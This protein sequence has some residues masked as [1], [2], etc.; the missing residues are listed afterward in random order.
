MTDDRDEAGP[1]LAQPSEA[2]ILAWAR[3]IS[4]ENLRAWSRAFTEDQLLEKATIVRDKLLKTSEVSDSLRRCRERDEAFGVP[5]MTL[6]PSP[7][8]SVSISSS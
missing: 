7:E 3:A 1:I 8:Y 2:E 4:E 6:W 5:I